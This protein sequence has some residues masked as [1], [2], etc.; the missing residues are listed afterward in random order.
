[1]TYVSNKWITYVL[2]IVEVLY[3]LSKALGSKWISNIILSEILENHDK[4]GE[5]CSHNAMLVLEEK[6]YR[7][8]KYSSGMSFWFPKET[9]G[10]QLLICAKTETDH[11]IQYYQD[12]TIGNA[13]QKDTA[14]SLTLSPADS[15]TMER[16]HKHPIF[17][18]LIY[19]F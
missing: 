4:C 16:I 6:G 7:I 10:E 14:I 15:T 9:N 13:T 2:T 12:A 3:A 17:I 8:G 5:V 1:M 18:F 19:F 11:A